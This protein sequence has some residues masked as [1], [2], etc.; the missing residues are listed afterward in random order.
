V[1]DTARVV[2]KGYITFSR[3]LF[4]ACAQNNKEDGKERRQGER[5]KQSEGVSERVRVSGAGVP[6][7]R[8]EKEGAGTLGLLSVARLRE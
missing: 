6:G 8:S 3:G 7:R 4:R 2:E 1:A 5:E